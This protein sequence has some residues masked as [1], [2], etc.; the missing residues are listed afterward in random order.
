MAK[1]RINE[2][3]YDEMLSLPDPGLRLRSARRLWIVR[4]E[5]G[6]LKPI[7]VEYL[8]GITSM[9]NL[10]GLLDFSPCRVRNGERR[11]KTYAYREETLDMGTGRHVSGLA[12]GHL[13]AP[14]GSGHANL[15][16]KYRSHPTENI[17]KETS[18]DGKYREANDG[19]YWGALLVYARGIRGLGIMGSVIY[20]RLTHLILRISQEE[21]EG[22]LISKQR[23]KFVWGEKAGTRDTQETWEWDRKVGT[24]E[25]TRDTVI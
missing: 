18:V 11:G 17:W 12:R 21:R 4:E 15:L 10:A 3:S 14:Q 19:E 6:N 16:S 8:L 2:C 22:R 1:I 23:L 20:R 25:I 7:D 24:P 9:Q 13:A 5:K